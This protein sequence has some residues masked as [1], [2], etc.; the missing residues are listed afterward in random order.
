MKKHQAN[1]ASIDSTILHLTRVSLVMVSLICVLLIPGCSLSQPESASKETTPVAPLLE[2]VIKGLDHV[3]MFVV[4]Y[5]DDPDPMLE[6]LTM[7]IDFSDSKDKSIE[8]QEIPLTVT[9]RL[10]GYEKE[11]DTFD[12][13]KMELVYQ[14]QVTMNRSMRWEFANNI[15]IPFDDIMVDSNSYYEYGTIEVIVKTPKQGDFRDICDRIQLY[16]AQ[17]VIAPPQGTMTTPAP[18]SEKTIK[19]LHHISIRSSIDCSPYVSA[20]PDSLYDGI[21][22]S[23][24][25]ED[26]ESKSIAFQEIPLTVTIQLYA[27]KGLLDYLG[28]EDRTLVYHQQIVIDRSMREWE[29]PADYIWIPFENIMV[30][31]NKYHRQG[32]IKV[33]VTTPMQGDFQDMHKSV[34]LYAKD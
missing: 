32:T 2:E 30:D 12:H 25:F 22:L 6:G 19:D 23:I 7:V 21:S 14:Q 27:G 1:Y 4:P 15:N 26:S 16:P 3:S 13:E 5:D 8:F 33:S 10:Y 31:S 29:S 24:S 34:P 28:I 17:P 11:R 20:Y 18:S 9:I